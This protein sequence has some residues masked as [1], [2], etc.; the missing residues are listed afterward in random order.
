M[1]KYASRLSV[2]LKYESVK[3]RIMNYRSKDQRWLDKEIIM[4]DQNQI[5]NPNNENS[6]L[7]SN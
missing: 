7:M 3:K 4:D 1:T 6:M 5:Q 2:D